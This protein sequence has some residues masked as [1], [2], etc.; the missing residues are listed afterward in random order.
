MF[1]IVFGMLLINLASAGSWGIVK[2]G[3]CINLTITT[4]ASACILSELKFPNSSSIAE[5]ITMTDLGNGRFNYETCNTETLGSYTGIGRCDTTPFDNDFEVTPS[6]KS[7]SSNQAFF[8][9]FFILAYGVGFFG[10]FGRNQLISFI[11]GILMILLGIFTIR[12]GIIIFRDVYTV[13]LSYITLGMGFIFM[14]VPAVEYL[15]EQFD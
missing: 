7:G 5:N 11:G 12:Y 9:I 15:Q 10:F 4:D 8:I 6:G 14:L 13:A 3:S 1:L 2:Q